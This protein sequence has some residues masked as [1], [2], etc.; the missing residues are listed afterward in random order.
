MTLLPLPTNPLLSVCIPAHNEEGNI[1]KTVDAVAQVLEESKIPYEFVIA[2]DNSKDGT[3]DIVISR[4]EAGIPIRMIDRTPPGGFGRAIRTCLSHFHG[5]IV[6]LVM[7]DLSDDPY[8]IVKYYRT[9]NEGYDAV[10]GSRFLPGSEVKDYPRVKLIANRLGNRLIQLLFRTHHND[11]TNAFKAYRAEALRSLFPLYG[12]HFNILIEMSLGV[13]IRDFK[14]AAVPIN[15]YGRTWG[16]ANF[17]IRQLGRRY[18]ST[19][20]K[21]YSERIFIMDDVLAEHEIRVSRMI[22]PEGTKE[23][24]TTNISDEND[25]YNWRGGFRRIESRA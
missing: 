10:Y 24:V 22:D 4:M 11:M 14:V 23:A 21:V 17:K 7:A 5:D 18:L 13:L 3:R 8:D 2:N 9:I 6:V 1:G 16:K 12:S 19:L 25:T 20:L 15:W